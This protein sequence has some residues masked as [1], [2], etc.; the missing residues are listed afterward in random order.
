MDGVGV[1]RLEG[2]PLDAGAG[3]N[4]IDPLE[5]RRAQSAQRDRSLAA[6]GGKNDCNLV[7][8][9]DRPAQAAADA[10]SAFDDFLDR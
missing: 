5:G 1:G 8:S 2:G 7:L 3:T 10:Q 6:F 9:G 4:G